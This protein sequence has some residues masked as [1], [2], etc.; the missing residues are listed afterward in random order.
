MELR[1]LSK[2]QNAQTMLTRVIKFKQKLI[3]HAGR[4]HQEGLE[5]L[6]SVRLE[7]GETEKEEIIKKI[8]G[9]RTSKTNWKKD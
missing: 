9:K 6:E 8:S 1:K 7:A 4:L 3:Q 5:H 2:T